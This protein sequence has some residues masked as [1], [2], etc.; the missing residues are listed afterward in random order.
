MSTAPFGHFGLTRRE[1]LARALGARLPE[2]WSGRAARSLLWR[3]ANGKARRPRDVTLFNQNVRLH[4]YDN[5]CEKRTFLTPHHWEA[6][7][8][9]ILHRFIE[10]L[11]SQE[12]VLVDVGANVGLYTLFCHDLA[13]ENGLAFRGL[14]I[15]PAQ[16]VRR[17]LC[18][19]LSFNNLDSKVTIIPH[20]I[21][22]GAGTAQ[23]Q[24]NKTNRGQSQ[25]SIHPPSNDGTTV[26]LSSLL[27]VVHSCGLQRID[28]LKMDIEGQEF[29]ALNAF[30]SDS[31]VTLYPSCALVEVA[32]TDDPAAIAALFLERDY[33]L[34][35]RHR[36]NAIFQR[37]PPA[38]GPATHG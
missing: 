8:R 7:E 21:G 37:L 6:T 13:R 28:I 27:D 9:S 24:I 32:H 22:A 30:F 33:E 31:P 17:R 29:S 12:L 19:N 18:E 5:I 16:T 20:A 25:I 3:F 15:E 1:V 14:C 2:T 10:T 11:D 36:G 4:P 34:V 35:L 38:N 26:Q 23:L